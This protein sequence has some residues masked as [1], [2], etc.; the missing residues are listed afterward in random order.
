MKGTLFSA[1]LF[2]VIA[3]FLFGW[4]FF[5]H[6]QVHPKRIIVA[7]LD[8]QPYIG[9]GLPGQGYV[10]QVV[11]QAF[12]ISGYEVEFLFLPWARVVDTAGFGDVVAYGPEYYS[13]E[14]A[15]QFLFSEPFPGGPAVLF[16]RADLDF[17]FNGLDSLIGHDVGVVRG[18]VNSAEFDAHP[19]LTLIEVKDDTTN[20]K[21][22]MNGRLD[23]IVADRFVGHWLVRRLFPGRSDELVVLAPSLA[24]HPL[25]ICFS[26]V[27]PDHEELAR[28]FN[29]GLRQLREDG[30]LEELFRRMRD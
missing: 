19:G 21:M 9:E 3:V 14:R 27:H 8:W 1:T 12:A 6:A 2:G 18:Y 29:A 30:T 22:L 24:E 10:A 20:V 17:S 23:F 28:V 15:E 25:Y 4:I 13:D 11:R 5:S 7:T 16:K 26:R